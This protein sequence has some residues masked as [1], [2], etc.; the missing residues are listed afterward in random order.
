MLGQQ[1]DRDSDLRPGAIGRNLSWAVNGILQLAPN[2]LLGLEAQQ[3]R[4]T[5]V[6]GAGT[7]VLNRYDVALAYLF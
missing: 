2:V 7:R 4:T 6:F 5:I 3:I 1:D